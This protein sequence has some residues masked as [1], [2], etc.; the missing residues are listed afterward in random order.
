MLPASE[1]SLPWH[2]QIGHLL[3]QRVQIRLEFDSVVLLALTLCDAAFE[4][5]P[6]E[7]RRLVWPSGYVIVHLLTRCTGVAECPT[8]HER[9]RPSLRGL[10]GTTPVGLSGWDT[11]VR[12][13]WRQNVRFGPLADKTVP[14]GKLRLCPLWSNGGHSASGALIQVNYGCAAFSHTE[15]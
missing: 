5:A 15:L 8:P 11:K 1:I 13:L 9:T 4:A 10:L 2:L 14:A 3:A 7:T 12:L 6:L